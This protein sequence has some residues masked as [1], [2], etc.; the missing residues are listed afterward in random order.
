MNE[1]GGPMK[2]N[3]TKFPAILLFLLVNFTLLSCEARKIP[4]MGLVDGRLR[5]CP[6]SPNCV[7]SEYQGKPF[8]EPLYFDESGEQAWERAKRV[9]REIGG[10]I[11]IEENGYLRAVF[12]SKIFRF[13]DDVEM[14]LEADKRRIHVRSSS[15]IGYYDFGVNRKRVEKIRQAFK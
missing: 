1:N 14:R 8:V 7:C 10:R 4:E 11:K 13:R 2:E 6:E 3:S 15:R 5:P 12:T 9:L